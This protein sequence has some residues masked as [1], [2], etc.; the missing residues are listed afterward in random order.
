MSGGR[1]IAELFTSQVDGVQRN[2]KS[3]IKG[4]SK[5]SDGVLVSEGCYNKLTQT[6]LK[7]KS[8]LSQFWRLD[9]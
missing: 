6:W 8:I 3:G 2:W 9:I 5:I 4:G 1:E 7:Q